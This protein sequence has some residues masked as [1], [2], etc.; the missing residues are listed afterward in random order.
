MRIVHTADWHLGRR[1]GRL[2]RSDDLR[3]AVGQVMG[4]CE[5]RD[6]DVLVIAGDLFDTVC[7]PDDVCAA[8]ELLKESI[9]PFLR[10]GGTVLA[11]TGNHDGETFCRTIGHALGLVDPAD[12]RPG[13]PLAKGRFHLFT[14]PALHRLADRSGREVQFVLMPYPLATRYP[15]D[16]ETPYQGGAEGR[17][18]QL[19][20]KFADLLGRM[21]SHERFDAGLHSVLVAHLFLQGATLPNGRVISADDEKQDV[22]CPSEDLGSG[23]AYVALGHVHKPQPMGDLAHVR[24][25]GSI[26][27]L[28]FDER[29]D[30]KEVVLL[31]IGP[32]GLRGRPEPL[33]LDATPF[34]DV[35]IRNPSEELPALRDHYPNADRAL[36]RFHATYTAGVDD[37]DEI[38]RRIDEVFPRCYSRELIEASRVNSS[39]PGRVS[40]ERRGFR[41]TVMDHLKGQ[42]EGEEIAEAVYAVAEE[43]IGEVRP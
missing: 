4:Y 15:D 35:K 34:L 27:R 1:Q 25:S 36:V 39:R 13:D 14:R 3:R 10:R 12:L 24:Y 30:R 43:L 26:E 29:E 19:R 6:A 11:V 8:V 38:H 41:E 16:A 23:W 31:E 33:H 42:L 9:R 17:H 21:R 40:A 37:P 22:V 28:A 20:E 18:R 2:D 7:R 5:S 32:D